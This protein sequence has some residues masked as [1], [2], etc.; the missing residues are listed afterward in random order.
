MKTLSPQH[1]L[2]GV[3]IRLSL[4]LTSIHTV[5]KVLYENLIHIKPQVLMQNKH[6][7]YVNCLLKLIHLYQF[8]CKYHW[9]LVRFLM[10]GGWPMLFQSMNKMIHALG[11]TNAPF[12]LH[13]LVQKKWNI[14]SFPT[15]RR[16]NKMKKS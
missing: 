3:Q 2:T 1:H 8:L 6:R 9:L 16:I 13:Q 4:K 15:L 10:T 5:Q 12:S 14:Y 11:K 7:F